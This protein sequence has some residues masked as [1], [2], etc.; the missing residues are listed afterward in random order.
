MLRDVESHLPMPWYVTRGLDL[1]S[2]CRLL[3][4]QLVSFAFIPGS[5]VRR[6]L[7]WAQSNRKNGI[8]FGCS[9]KGTSSNLACIF[10]C[11]AIPASG[12]WCLWQ[13]TPPLKT[14]QTRSCKQGPLQV[15]A[16]L[17]TFFHSSKMMFILVLNEQNLGNPLL[18]QPL[19]QG[20]KW[21]EQV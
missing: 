10:I 12:R 5:K 17:G 14:M 19:K 8:E 6:N 1:K 13:T 16:A 21:F 11:Q 3:Q 2:P 18:E 20:L 7:I 15:H 4:H 9:L